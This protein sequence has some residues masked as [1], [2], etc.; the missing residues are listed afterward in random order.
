MKKNKL[1]KLL[2]I[3]C[4]PI[5]ILGC[6]KEIGEEINPKGTGADFGNLTDTYQE[7]DAGT[8][9]I[10]FRNGTGEFANKVEVSFG[11]S[12]T[13]GEDF[14]LAGITEDGIELTIL[15]DDL[16]EG[17]EKI[18]VT[19][20]PTNGNN[21][22]TVTLFDDC[23]DGIPCDGDHFV[24]SLV[25]GDVTLS[26]YDLTYDADVVVVKNAGV[27]TIE[28]LNV[29]FMED[30]WGETVQVQEPVVFTVNECYEITI[31]NQYIFTTLYS[32]NLYDYQIEGS[33]YLTPD[34]KMVLNY[35]VI[36]DG[37]AVGNWCHTNGNPVYMSDPVFKAVLTTP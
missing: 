36:Q 3:F 14:E 26:R 9:L 28:G 29:G 25:G 6:E 33:G 13:E 27:Y 31:E 23:T 7:G 17:V 12:A 21:T 11:G 1:I 35:D 34:C 30:F 18:K 10:P 19:I 32:G 37:F 24:G 2:F 4:L 5:L 16:V 15:D 22:F 20:S 8:L